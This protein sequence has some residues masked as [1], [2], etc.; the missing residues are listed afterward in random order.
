MSVEFAVQKSDEAI[1]ALRRIAGSCAIPFPVRFDGVGGKVTCLE[2]AAANASS[3]GV[4][5][6]Y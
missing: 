1:V 6:R 2:A 4:E 5:L 3:D